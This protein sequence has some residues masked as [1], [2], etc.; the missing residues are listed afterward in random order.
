MKRFKKTELSRVLKWWLGLPYRPT[1]SEP[2]QV[3]KKQMKLLI[4]GAGGVASWLVPLLRKTVPPGSEILVMDGDLLE[5]RNLDRQMFPESYLGWNKAE[6]LADLYKISYSP[7]Y[8]SPDSVC[9]SNGANV[10]GIF[11]CADNHPARAST[12][13]LVDQGKAKWAIIGGNEYT[14]SEAYAYQAPWKGTQFDPR[15]FYP[16]INTDESGDPL[17]PLAC[18]GVAQIGHP[19]LALANYLAAGFMAHLYWFTTY[20]GHEVTLENWPKIHQS[21]FAIFN[22]RSL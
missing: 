10:E 14:D 11:C 22:S 5:P 7:E 1:D 4:V 6:A 13:E 16:E 3:I 19:Q 20:H 12:L 17:N 21:N 9:L 8:L 18:Q 2:H 15:V